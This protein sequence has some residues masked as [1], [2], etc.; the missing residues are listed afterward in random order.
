M[1]GAKRRCRN[2]YKVFFMDVHENRT[3]LISCPG[4]SRMSPSRSRPCPQMATAQY[5]EIVLQTH[6]LAQAPEGHTPLLRAQCP[7]PRSVLSN[8]RHEPSRGFLF[9]ELRLVQSLDVWLYFMQELTTRRM[10]MLFVRPETVNTAG[11]SVGDIT[12]TNDC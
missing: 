7:A 11:T 8:V 10:M 4:F 9:L 5:G 6:S 1:R 3:A 2:K 12:N